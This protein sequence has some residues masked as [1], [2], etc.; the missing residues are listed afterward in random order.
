MAPY[1]FKAFIVLC[2]LVQGEVTGVA[3]DAI[4]NVVASSSKDRTAR[5]WRPTLCAPCMCLQRLHLLRWAM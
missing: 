2:S 5:I 4:N 1:S 3:Y